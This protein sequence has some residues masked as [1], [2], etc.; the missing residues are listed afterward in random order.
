[1]TGGINK[2][3]VRTR[4]SRDLRVG[5]G[6]GL[7]PLLQSS[8]GNLVKEDGRNSSD[9]RGADQHYDGSYGVS[10]SEMSG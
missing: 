10:A 5:H 3:M 8:A 2:V 6:N 7:S 1:M 4:I 9:D